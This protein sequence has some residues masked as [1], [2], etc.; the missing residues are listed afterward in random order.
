M[1]CV[2]RAVEGGPSLGRSC[3]VATEAK[4]L[5]GIVRL[6]GGV[7]EGARWERNE[8]SSCHMEQVEATRGS[9]DAVI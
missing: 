4:E 3:A 2:D 5:Q 8:R 7:K 1:G 9:A 6:E